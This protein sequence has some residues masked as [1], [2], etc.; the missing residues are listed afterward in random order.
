[1]VDGESAPRGTAIAYYLKTAPTV[2]V[3]VT[4]TNTAT[5][6][7]VRTCVGPKDVGLNRFVWAMPVIRRRVAADKAAVA[8]RADAADAPVARR[9]AGAASPSPSPSPTPTGPTPCVAAA[10][11]GGGRGG[12]GGGGGF[13]GG[14]GGIGPGVYKVTLAIG[15]AT[16]GTQT[17]SILDDIWLG[18]K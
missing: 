7:A 13:G 9:Q 10:G 5:G 17:F 18:E 6:N 4:I 14:G 12:G 11:G 2:D 15:G 16:V 1:V 8:A 3:I